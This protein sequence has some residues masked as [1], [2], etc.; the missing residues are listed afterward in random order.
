MIICPLWLYSSCE[1]EENKLPGTKPEMLLG[2]WE[3]TDTFSEGFSSLFGAWVI[4]GHQ[5]I[6][7]EFTETG[8]SMTTLK[9]YIEEDKYEDPFIIDFT[10]WSYEGETIYFEKKYRK[11][12]VRH[13]NLS[14]REMTPDSIKLGSIYDTYYK[15]K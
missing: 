12:R 7:Y 13:W 4:I 3:K 2:K 11:D 5:W 9:Y 14:I 8:G 6:T 15:V 1:E 10:D